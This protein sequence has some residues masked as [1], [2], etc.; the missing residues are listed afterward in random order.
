[1][2]NYDETDHAFELTISTQDQYNDSCGC[3]PE[4]RLQ[5]HT[6][7]A[8]IPDDEISP[9]LDDPGSWDNQFS[10]KHMPCFVAALAAREEARAAQKRAEEEL[11][12]ERQIREQLLQQQRD[13]REFDR[14]REKL[15]R[16]Q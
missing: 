16:T 13:E 12:R 10:P 1:M 2:W 15:G 14:L 6:S 9:D 7:Y 4:W 8:T 3:H 5:S 11:A